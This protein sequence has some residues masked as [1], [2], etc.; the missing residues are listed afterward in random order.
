M[1]QKNN[2]KNNFKAGKEI[3][4]ATASKK[5]IPNANV[6]ISLGIIDNQL[7]VAD[8]QMNNTIKNLT[9]N[10]NICVLGGYFRI[11]GKAKIYDSG[12]YFNFCVLKNKDYVVKNAIL[13]KIK[14]V[15]DLNKRKIIL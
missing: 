15:Y 1:S 4:L 12:K 8:C 7:L 6:V 5:G 11:I 9:K 3:I 13:I 14:N 10:P 2:W